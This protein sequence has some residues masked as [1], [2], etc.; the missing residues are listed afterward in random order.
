MKE[1]KSLLFVSILRSEN[2]EWKRF[3]KKFLQNLER[4]ERKL[5]KNLDDILKYKISDVIS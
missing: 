3:F 5:I 2:R 1:I 4:F